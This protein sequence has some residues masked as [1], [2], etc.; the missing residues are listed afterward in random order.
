MCLSFSNEHSFGDLSTGLPFQ[1]LNHWGRIDF[2]ETS[3]CINIQKE[4]PLQTNDPNDVADFHARVSRIQKQKRPNKNLFFFVFQKSQKRKKKKEKETAATTVRKTKV[5]VPPD[6]D[7]VSAQQKI[8][9]VA[10]KKNKQTNN[11]APP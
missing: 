9:Y 2:S 4:L 11:Q 5:N 6:V 3:Y 8:C 1:L 10:P 7:F